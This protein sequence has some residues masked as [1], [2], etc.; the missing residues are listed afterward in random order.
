MIIHEYLEH[1]HQERS[2]QGLGNRLIEP[3]AANTNSGE[4]IVR[5]RERAGGLLSYYHWDAA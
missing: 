2:H 1:Y 4:G 3:I 5:R